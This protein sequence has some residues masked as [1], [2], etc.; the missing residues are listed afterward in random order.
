MY[1]LPIIDCRVD[2]SPP[3]RFIVAFPSILKTD[4]SVIWSCYVIVYF[5]SVKDTANRFEILCKLRT[6]SIRGQMSET[7]PYQKLG[8]GLVR[9]FL[10]SRLCIVFHVSR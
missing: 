4:K 10:G 9:S 7:T 8:D 6:I 3:Q 2:V 5:N 1:L